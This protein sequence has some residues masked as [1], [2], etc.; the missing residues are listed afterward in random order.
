W[1]PALAFAVVALFGA[2]AIYTFRG[3]Q[4]GTG[5]DLARQASPAPPV[6]RTE[7]DALKTP[8]S[9]VT[10]AR[11]PLAPTPPPAD[12][13]IAMDLRPRAG[14]PLTR[15]E[16]TEIAG[17]PA[18]RRIY[19]EVRGARREEVR[20]QLRRRLPADNRFSLTDDVGE[21]EVALIAT[22]TSSRPDRL[23]LTVRLTDPQGKVLWP[24][25]PGTSGRQYTGSLEKVVATFSRELAADLQQLEQQ[26]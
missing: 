13:V 22:V 4:T 3:R 10:P 25:T 15:G 23:A 18:A 21:A 8:D 12:E 24:L 26:K 7:P 14:E 19:L 9:T 17:L 2:A 6:I 20:R 1:R 5:A 11:G 16:A